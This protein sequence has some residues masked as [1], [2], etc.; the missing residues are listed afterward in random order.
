M[1]GEWWSMICSEGRTLA[2]E[3]REHNTR[4]DAT[5]GTRNNQ[6]FEGSDLAFE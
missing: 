2:E 4:G 6:S 3:K 5:S 1:W